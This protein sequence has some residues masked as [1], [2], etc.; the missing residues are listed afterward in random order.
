MRYTAKRSG[1][2]C[3]ARALERDLSNRDDTTPLAGL[4][5]RNR[6]GPRSTIAAAHEWQNPVQPKTLNKR[7]KKH[8]FFEVGVCLSGVGKTRT[9]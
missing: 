6:S 4:Q 9:R 3:Q 2:S 5:P 7:W 1:D 8:R